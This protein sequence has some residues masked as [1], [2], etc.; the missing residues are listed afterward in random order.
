MNPAPGRE[1]C[2]RSLV[3]R[4]K[5]GTCIF[6]SK[7]IRKID[8]DGERLLFKMKRDDVFS[9]RIRKETDL[10][11]VFGIPLIRDF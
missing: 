2:E 7:E 3:R 5:N 9:R 10:L 8:T 6:I 4:I 1:P 11:V